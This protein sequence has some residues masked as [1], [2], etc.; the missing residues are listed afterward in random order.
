MFLLRV[1]GGLDLE[2]AG[3]EEVRKVTAQPKRAALL[4]RLALA[5]QFVRRDTLLALLWP[6]ADTSHA[7]AALRQAVRFLRQHLGEG[8]VIS[9][10]EEE[11]GVDESQ[12]SCD[13]VAFSDALGRGDDASAVGLYRGDLL[14]GFFIA[15]APEFDQWLEDERKEL[16][17]RAAAAALRSSERAAA[18]A[19][20]ESAVELARLAVAWSAYDETVVRAVLQSFEA[21]ELRAPALQI[22]DDYVQ[23]LDS[24]LGMEVDA[25]TAALAAGIRS[26]AS[27]GEGTTAAARS[28]LDPRRVL[29]VEFENRTA[30]PLLDHLGSMAA[31]WIAQGL[32]DVGMF[33][34]VPHTAALSTSRFFGQTEAG[35]EARVRAMAVD[36][37]AGTVVSGVYYA[38]GDGE[39]QFQS[40]ITHAATGVIQHAIAPVAASRSAPFAAVQA[41]REQV[42]TALAPAFNDRVTHVAAARPPNYEAYRDYIEGLELFLRGEWPAALARFEDASAADRDY[43]LP[44]IVAAITLWN[45]GRLADAHAIADDVAER[46]DLRPFEGAVLNM[47]RAWLR[48]DWHAAHE[49]VFQQTKMAP[50]SIA[51]FG[52]A[53]ELRRMHRPAEAVQQ[54]MSLDPARG[55]MRGWLFYWIELTISLHHLGRHDEELQAARRAR[56][57]F[58]D[59]PATL[60]MEVR[61]NAARRD[62]PAVLRTID[63]RLSMPPHRPPDPGAL[64][65]EAALELRAHGCSEPASRLFQRS[66]DW[67]LHDAPEEIRRARK[68]DVALALYYTEQWQEAGDAFAALGAE[69]TGPMQ[70]SNRDHP[71][72]QIHMPL[73][74]VGAIALRRGDR[75]QAAAAD[76]RLAG[77]DGP[78]LYGRNLYW[79]GVFAAL[80]GDG[81]RATTLLRQAFANGLPHEIFIHTDPHLESL[82]DE[83]SFQNLMH[84]NDDVPP[85]PRGGQ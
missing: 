64:L 49:A 63:R 79:R 52:V 61:A 33:E 23:R 12:L 42:R 4:I 77:L 72:L 17:R 28:R 25:E 40:V 78:Y 51:S 74:Y 37:G 34:V 45:L 41:L 70:L 47:L 84:P 81:A 85:Q 6:D 3:G 22:Y 46:R 10:G 75:D 24:D 36:Q 43:A 7:R 57:L 66:L 50:G 39:L 58:H 73:G 9:R 29:V 62:I 67:Y 53:E 32:A 55:E 35:R 21:A 65:R 68:A 5:K 15:D 27:R 30:D 31:D 13:A 1:L 76:A 11:L 19:D 38:S 44:R 82:R 16:R 56:T 59:D 83:A 20:A 8:V 71:Q 69:N 26:G 14:P 54:L 60:L 2:T 18:R 48:G 80:S